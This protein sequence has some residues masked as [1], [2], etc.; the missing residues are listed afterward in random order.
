MSA[1]YF[2]DTNVLVYSRDA[3]EPDKQPRAQQWLAALWEKRCG[4]TSVQVLSEYYVT[5][6]RKLAPGLTPDEAWMDVEA[7]LAWGPQAVNVDV[8]RGARSASQGSALS[9][10][11]ALIVAAAKTSNCAFVLTEDLQDGQDLD[12]MRVIN[13]FQHSPAELQS[14]S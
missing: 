7:L 5:V 4:R 8:L 12:G 1:L 9:W 6:T 3:S 2:V 13:P 10:W 11:D 14:L